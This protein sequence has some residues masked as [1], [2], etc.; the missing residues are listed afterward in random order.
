[1]LSSFAAPKFALRAL[2]QSLTR[3]F[4][5]QGIHV[6]HVIVDGVIDTPKTKEWVI[7]DGRPDSKLSPEAI[8]DSYWALHEQGRSC[9]THELDVR[10]WTEKW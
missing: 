6:S 9:W 5:P 8:A 1:M 7:G 4:G 3:E 10:P 2:A